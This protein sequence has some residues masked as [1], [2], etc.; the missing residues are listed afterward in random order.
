MAT[1][2]KADLQAQVTRLRKSLDRTRANNGALKKSLREALDREQATS[3][4]LRVI[5]RSSADVQPVFDGIANAG[6]HRAGAMKRTASG[7]GA[8]RR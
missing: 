6:Q 5:A 7:I 2:K 4:I 3:E 8:L 1:A